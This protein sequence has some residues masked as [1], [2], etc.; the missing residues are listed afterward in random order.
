MRCLLSVEPV[1]TTVS[2][3]VTTVI[4]IIL[5]DSPSLPQV[6]VGSLPLS[7]AL[8]CYW[9]PAPFPACPL[10]SPSLQ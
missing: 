2:T 7:P 4:S 3:V 9:R 6:L 10:P 1:L 8:G 5:I